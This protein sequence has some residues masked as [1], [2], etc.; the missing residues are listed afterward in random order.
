MNKLSQPTMTPE[1]LGAELGIDPK[2]IRNVLRTYFPRPKK[3]KNKP[4]KVTRG[5]AMAIRYYY[6]TE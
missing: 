4:W 5:M 1:E 6:G 3:K 2:S